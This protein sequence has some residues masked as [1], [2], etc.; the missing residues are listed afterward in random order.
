M[1]NE[2]TKNHGRIRF[3]GDFEL[4]TR[5]YEL[6]RSGRPLRLERIPMEVLLLL[7]ER[8]GQL[9]TREEIVERIWGRE[10]YL[11]TDNSING[12]IRKLRQALQDDPEKPRII[13]TI[14]GR[15]YRFIAEVGDREVDEASRSAVFVSPAGPEEK[16]ETRDETARAESRSR[17]ALWAVPVGLALA[18]IA[19]L[20]IYLQRS[21][22][23]PEPAAGRLMLAVLPFENLTGDPAQEYPL[24]DP[25]RGDPRFQ[26]VLRRAGLAK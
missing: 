21:G 13:Q 6:R 12:A 9:V 16:P 2:P 4:D 24:Y 11:D 22:P 10:V 23:R 8:K 18:L 20:V 7:I 1:A 14:T 19:G 5:A 15:G 17:S 26:D 3:G 25:V